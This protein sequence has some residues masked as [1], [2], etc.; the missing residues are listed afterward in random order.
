M[1]GEFGIVEPLDAVDTVL[2]VGL[3]VDAVHWIGITGRYTSELLM[4]VHDHD[5]HVVAA[6]VSTLEL[7]GPLHGD[8]LGE[9]LDIGIDRVVHHAD[10]AALVHPTADEL[11]AAVRPH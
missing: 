8:Q 6:F 9:L 11:L 2:V 7:R 1:F 5:E 3:D 4:K 10:E